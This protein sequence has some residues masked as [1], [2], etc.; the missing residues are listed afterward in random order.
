MLF[1]NVYHSKVVS[2]AASLVPLNLALHVLNFLELITQ[3]H[4]GEIDHTGIETKS[5]T[6]R[7]LDGTGRIEA[8]NEVMAFAVAGLVFGGDLGQAED[9]P[10]GVAT[11]D[12]AGTDDLGTSVTGD[13][14]E[15]C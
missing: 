6:D 7:C 4:D 1:A 14:V 8:H 5:T 13:S 3:F 9:A 2:D 12:A 15:L 10:V 11:D